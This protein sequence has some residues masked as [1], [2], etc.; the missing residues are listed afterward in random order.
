MKVTM[1]T[2]VQ[3]SESQMPLP[4]VAWEDATNVRDRSFVSA[5][6][7]DAD[8]L[9]LALDVLVLLISLVTLIAKALSLPDWLYTWGSVGMATNTAIC[10]LMLSICDLL[11]LYS[12]YR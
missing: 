1:Q 6:Q 5:K 12:K 11:A 3:R 2:E 8:F 7:T 4:P 9:R 10:L